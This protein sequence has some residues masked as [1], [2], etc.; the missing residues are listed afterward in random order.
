MKEK[1]VI[2]AMDATRLIPPGCS[3]MVGGF[4]ACGSPHSILAALNSSGP[5]ELTLITNDTSVHDLATGRITGV[6]HLVQ[7]RLFRKIIASHIGANHEA[8]RQMN[9][10]ETEVDL[11]PQGTLAERIRSGGAGL[12]GVLTKTGLGTEV[13]QGKQVVHAEGQTYLLEVALR[14]DVAIIKAHRADRAGNL[15]FRGTARN[16]NPLMATAAALVIAEVEEI[17]EIGA[18]APDEVHTPSVLVDYLVLADR[19]DW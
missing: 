7:S 6:A 16:F 1:P 2:T 12:G 17:V 8:Q 5:K 4:M 13:A 15:V 11:V 10:G 18:L 14:A 9:A 19:L 3:L